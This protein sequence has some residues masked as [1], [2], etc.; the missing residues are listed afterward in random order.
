MQLK[1][2]WPDIGLYSI[3]QACTLKWIGF[4]SILIVTFVGTWLP[5]NMTLVQFLVQVVESWVFLIRDPS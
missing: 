5:Q 2:I 1:N 3:W 4:Q